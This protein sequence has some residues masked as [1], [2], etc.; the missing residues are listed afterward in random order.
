MK[1][2][3]NYDFFDA[4]KN[5]NEPLRPMKIIRN[6]KKKYSILFPLY[7]SIILATKQIDT[8]NLIDTR[9]IMLYMMRSCGFCMSL[10]FAVEAIIKKLSDSKTDAYA[11]K[12]SERLKRLVQMLDTINVNTTYDM[13]LEAELYYK[14]THIETEK[15]SLPVLKN[16]KYIYIPAYGFD[17]QEKT[18]SIL[19]E[20]II[21]TRAYELSV[22]EPDREYRRVLAKSHI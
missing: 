22:D 8:S 18:T 4:I 12:A 20:H 1:L 16:E 11:Q 5:V 17:G 3:I 14:T 10:D 7:L 6:E 2:L 19:Q 13:L 9:Y 21:G 15:G